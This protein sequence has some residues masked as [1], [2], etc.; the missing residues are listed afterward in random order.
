MAEKLKI[1]VIVASTRPIRNGG[2]VAEWVKQTTDK[3]SEADYTYF[4]LAELNLPFLAE[5]KTPSQGDYQ[6]ESTKQWAEKVG[7]Q[8]GFLIVTPEY[9]HGYP[10]SLKNA[11]DTLYQEWR[12][13]PVAYVGYGVIGAARSIEQINNV[14]LNLEMHPIVNT[15][16]NLM[17]FEFMNEKG[18]FVPAE[19]HQQWLN[20][21]LASLK[22]WTGLFNKIR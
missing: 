20:G 13:K 1:G 14:V 11:L 10:A 5:P 17:L 6:L 18:E 21:T 22:E 3:D 4:D 8:D 16:T 2:Q 7:A 9:N 15:T 12:R 19:K